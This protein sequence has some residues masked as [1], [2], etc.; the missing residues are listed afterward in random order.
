[1]IKLI[2]GLGNPG[3]TYAE[4]RHN[5]GAWFVDAAVEKYHLHLKLESKFSL[6]LAASHHQGEKIFFAKTT[7]YMNESGLPI[8][9]FAHFYDIEPAE[10][11]VVHD[12]LDFEPGLIKL[13][14]GGGHAGHNGLRDIFSHLGSP[15]FHRLRI[16]IGH[17]GSKEKVAGFVL[18]PPQKDEKI[19]IK[20][21][22]ERALEALP[23]LIEG[24]FVAAAREIQAH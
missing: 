13:K 11:L 23:T 5:V 3:P 22:L 20:F 7:R 16:G 17:P 12:E 15:D 2:V 1:M 9:S 24:N 21:S 19:A 14:T 10:I 6:V 18:H 8:A 4:T